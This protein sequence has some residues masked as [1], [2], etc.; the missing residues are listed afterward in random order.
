LEPLVQNRKE[1]IVI[2][3]ANHGGAAPKKTRLNYAPMAGSVLS[4]PWRLSRR[5]SHNTAPGRKNSGRPSALTVAPAQEAARLT[6]N[7]R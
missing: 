1:E 3:K 2:P 5:V 7:C 4:A 6:P